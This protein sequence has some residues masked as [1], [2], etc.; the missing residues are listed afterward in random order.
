MVNESPDCHISGSDVSSDKLD[1]AFLFPNDF[2]L[3]G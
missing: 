1:I 2:A 3:S